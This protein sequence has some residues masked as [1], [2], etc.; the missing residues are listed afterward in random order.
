[1]TLGWIGQSMILK[2]DTL[3]NN[4]MKVFNKLMPLIRRIDLFVPITGLSLLAIVRAS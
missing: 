3:G 1:G 4:N 2:R